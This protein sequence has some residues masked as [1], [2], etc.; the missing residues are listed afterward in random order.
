M[1]KRRAMMDESYDVTTPFPALTPE[2]RY[3]FDVFG[4]VIIENTLPQ[5]EIDVL[6]DVLAQLKRD[7]LGGGEVGN[8][9]IHK[10]TPHQLTVERIYEY[11]PAIVEYL[12]HPWLIAIAEEL[13]GGAVR[14][15]S[16][17]AIVNVRVP[18][19]ADRPAT[20][21]FHKGISPESGAFTRNG[22]FHTTMVRAMTNLT[23]LGPEDGGTVLIAGSH[24]IA[25]TGRDPEL[26][27]D[28]GAIIAAAY[29]NEALIHQFIAPAGST[30][31]FSE[32]TIHATGQIRSDRERFMISGVYT[33]T[34]FQAWGGEGA[35][36]HE[37]SAALMAQ[38]PAQQRS[39]FSGSRSWEPGK[40]RYRTLDLPTT[41][42]P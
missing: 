20:Y 22:L 6:K 2:Q 40:Q 24:K 34:M 39:L 18:E 26:V 8:I 14:I 23:D 25:P 15:N 29:K 17:T 33:P 27:E 3:Y 32:S 12:T 42:Q 11:H 28:D 16:A 38:L 7:V 31:I 9:L 19:T 21:G 37:P 10:R 5:A 30:L 35:P 13:S 41:G 4:Y 36:S 1:K